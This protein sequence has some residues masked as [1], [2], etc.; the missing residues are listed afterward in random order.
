MSGGLIL[1]TPFVY[2]DRTIVPVV[3]R[4]A[5]SAS[6]GMA[7]SLDPV[8]LLV[9]DGCSWGIAV[10]DDTPLERLLDRLIFPQAA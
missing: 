9:G 8:A 4:T 10:L 3:R 7:L 1:G 5:L 2:G 6:H